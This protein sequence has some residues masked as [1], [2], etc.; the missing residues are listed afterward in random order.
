MGVPLERRALITS[1][2]IS[3]YSKSN[4]F[5]KQTSEASLLRRYSVNI[6]PVLPCSFG[7]P[8]VFYG[9]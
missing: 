9:L 2:L 5:F 4:R 7:I 8:A 1:Y 6:P 3:S